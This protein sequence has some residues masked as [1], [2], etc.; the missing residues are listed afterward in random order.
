[1]M[2]AADNL[3]GTAE[4]GGPGYS[5]GYTGDGTVFE[6]AKGSSTITTLASFNGTDGFYPDGGLVLDAAGNLYGTA[7]LGG[8]GYSGASNGDGTVFEVAK[9]SGTITTLASFDG[10]DGKSP[11]GGLCAGRRRQPRR[12][13]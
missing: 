5:G 6:V 1:M 4:D 8:P 2:D 7:V 12:D 10:A 13:H 9:G 11:N 3:Y